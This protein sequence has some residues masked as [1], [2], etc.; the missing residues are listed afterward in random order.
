MELQ[1][2]STNSKT[3]GP[4]T[5]ANDATTTIVVFVPS[6]SLGKGFYLFVYRS[7]Y[8]GEQRQNSSSYLLSCCFKGFS[9]IL[10][11]FAAP[12]DV[13]AKSPCAF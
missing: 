13:R 4:T 6:E 10:V 11:W 8:P 5:A 7:N 1:Q 2:Q 9:K 3:K 12:P